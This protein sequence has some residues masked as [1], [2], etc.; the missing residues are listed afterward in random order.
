MIIKVTKQEELPMDLLLL[1]DPSERLVREYVS[2]SENY[3]LIEKDQTIGVIVLLPT[4][5]NTLEIVNIAIDP[6]YQGKGYAKKL[7]K[8]AIKNAKN[9]GFKH[10]EIGTA[11]SSINQL[12]LY[13]KVGFRINYIDKDFFLKN[14]HD[15]I[16][17]NHIQA[18]D[19]IRLHMDIL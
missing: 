1:A 5:P 11:N 9:K 18:I 19:M 17:E 16:Y 12:A 8:F 15:E 6:N 7:L 4:R 3:I 10:I 14:Y 13:Q 2:R